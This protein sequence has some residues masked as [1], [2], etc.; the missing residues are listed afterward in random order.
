MT[1]DS[2]F[3]RT[4]VSPPSMLS[5]APDQAPWDMKRVFMSKIRDRGGFTCHHA[6]FDKA[7]LINEDNLKLSQRD[8]Q[9]KWRLY[10]QLKAGYS[11]EDLYHRI[12]RGV[13]C[14]IAQGVTHCRSF[15]D[16][17]ALVGLLP[18]K[19]ALEVR[20]AY[21]HHI[22]LEFAI[23]PLEG[24]LDPEA[25]R[26]FVAACEL[27]DIIGGLPSRDRPYPER[28]LDF[29]MN[30][31][32]DLDKP[33][34]VHIDQENQPNER[35]TEL[36]ARA[37][38]KHGLEGK[39]RGIH[40]ISLAAQDYNEQH[41]VIELIRE[42]DMG[43]I[44][45]PSAAISMKPHEL[46]APLHNSIAPLQRLL[47]GGVKLALGADNIHDLFMPLVDG[48]LWFESR[49]LMEATRCYDLDM[50]ADLATAR[51]G[52]QNQKSPRL[53]SYEMSASDK[54]SETHLSA[55]RALS[56]ERYL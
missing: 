27:A 18:L 34:D 21:R 12:S 22:H 54:M 43:I 25:Q 4:Q 10:R 7:Y 23:Q 39:V 51:W 44:I 47:E 19:V 50:I 26:S 11:Y 41:R 29:I 35:E 55:L 13:E 42:A 24:V 20:E 15:I 32:K 30:L 28:H 31:A 53:T 33:I 49:L 17:D 14:M 37:T 3:L 46:S 40:A 52:F 5:I 16:A 1:T 45:C 8:M 6:H 9:D 38:I 2:I 36:L 56:T 48:D